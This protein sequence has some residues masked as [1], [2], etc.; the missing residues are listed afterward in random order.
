MLESHSLFKTVVGNGPGIDV[1]LFRLSNLVD[2]ATSKDTLNGLNFTGLTAAALV[3]Y[4]MHLHGNPEVC[5]H[6]WSVI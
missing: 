6:S 1:F 2:G 4:D 3:V 5:P